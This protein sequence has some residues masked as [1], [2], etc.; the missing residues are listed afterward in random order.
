MNQPVTDQTSLSR[1]LHLLQISQAVTLVGSF[2][3]DLSTQECIWT[4]ALFMLHDLPVA[5]NNTI[6]LDYAL[7]RVR[8]ADQQRVRTFLSQEVLEDVFEFDFQITTPAGVEKFIHARVASLLNEEN[9]PVNRGNF[10]DVTDL[11]KLE[12]ELQNSNSELLIKAEIAEHAEAISNSGSYEWNLSSGKMKYSNN[13]YRIFG[14][15]S[16]SDVPSFDLFVKLVHPEDRERVLSNREAIFTSADTTV[17]EYRIQLANGEIKHISSRNT[18]TSNRNGEEILVGSVRDIS[19]EYHILKQLKE[20]TLLA[21]SISDNNVD[22]IAAYDKDLRFTWW[23]KQSEEKFGVLRSE[24]IGKHASEVFSFLKGTEVEKSLHS[25][26]NGEFVYLKDK[27]YADKKGYYESFVIPLQHDEEVFGVL[28]ITHDLTEMKMAAQKLNTVNKALEQKN[29]ELEKSNNELVA[30]SYVASHDLQ[31]PLRKI[32]TFSE[33]LLEKELDNLSATG[34]DYLKRMDNASVRMQTLIE[35]LLAFS[36]TTTT[37]THFELKD[38]NVLLHD[39]SVNLKEV[40]EEAKGVI[41]ADQLPSA[42]VVDFQF[43][44]MLENLLI[45]AL[46]YRKESEPPRIIIKCA[47]V[48][49][50]DDPFVSNTGIDD[51]YLITIQDNGIGFEQEYAEKIFEIFQRL[52]GKHEYSGTGIGLAICKKTIENHHGRIRAEG[53][54]G[55]GSTFF[56]YLPKNL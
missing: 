42:K 31:E 28:V 55:V 12:R 15:E 9:R 29:E 27:R 40:I 13:L 45:N 51:Y 7:H 34:K 16:S 35:D 17:H 22:M 53:V 5:N 38:L 26:L 33:R 4:D 2:E 43:Q 10:Q 49:A 24:V 30:F 50:E 56:V 19:D 23:N 8:S 54:L 37:P 1:K 47:E 11:R 3:I 25:A 39:V 36:R 52:H 6:S 21:E 14:L 32:R 48:K 44:Q 20:R 18:K 46:K 41:L